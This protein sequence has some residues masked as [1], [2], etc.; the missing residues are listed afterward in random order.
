VAEGEADREA[1]LAR[2]I[3]VHRRMVALSQRA[4]APGGSHILQYDTAP[5]STEANLLFGPA[6]E[7]VARLAA[8]RAAGVA[9]G[10]GEQRRRE[11][12]REPA[13]LRQAG[14]AGDGGNVGCNKPKA[15]CTECAS[16]Q[17]SALLGA[18]RS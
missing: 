13:P 16:S 5:G 14:D 10:A 4:G 8:L 6:E 15:H 11:A 1:A 12:D 9:Q 7:I 2:Q 18:H 3:A 17:G